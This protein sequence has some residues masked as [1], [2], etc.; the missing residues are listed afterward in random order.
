MIEC[1]EREHLDVTKNNKGVLEC[2][3]P[4]AR[5]DLAIEEDIAE[6]VARV[7]GYDNIPVN[8]SGCSSAAGGLTERQ[9]RLQKIRDIMI[10]YGLNEC[11]TFSFVGERNFDAAGYDKNNKKRDC[12]RI[13]N[14]L[15]EDYALM[16]TTLIPSM[17]Q[18][19]ALNMRNKVYS[20]KL[21]E[22][23]NVHENKPDKD[24]LPTQ[25]T[26]L[27]IGAVGEAFYEV[28]GYIEGLL[29]QM[30]IE[31]P[32]FKKE[33]PEYYHPGR[34]AKIWAGDAAIGEIGEIHPDVLEKQGMDKRAVVAEVEL[35]MLLNK[36]IRAKRYKPLP[37]YPALERDIAVTV[38]K[39]TEI[40]PMI[41]F[42]KEKGGEILESV[43]LFDIYQGEQAGAG[44]KS[45][46]FSLI[47]RAERNLTDIEA[48]KMLEEIEKDLGEHFGAKLRSN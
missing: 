10:S 36:E 37:K 6:E 33:A 2:T 32:V 23:S 3:I 17:M 47:F 45:V 9:K 41:R 43:E 31:E 5:Q 39:K 1:L 34:K 21:F 29:N 25:R 13:E 19:V 16:R 28:K 42:I 15:S 27:C 8:N 14:P 46:A 48:N 44:N 7:Y 26:V 30:G 35:D 12:V 38:A 40:G 11:M 4:Y 24:G 22:I 20:A 18:A